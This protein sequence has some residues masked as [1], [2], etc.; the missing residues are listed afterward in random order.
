[1]KTIWKEVKDLMTKG[2]LGLAIIGM[3]SLYACQQ[4]GGEG[5]QSDAE[6]ADSTQMGGNPNGGSATDAYNMDTLK[7]TENTR[8]MDEVGTTAG[9]G[10]AGTTSEGNTDTT[11]ET[12]GTSSQSGL[13]KQDQ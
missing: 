11:S 2:T 10:A 6:T 7:G 13:K 12:G 1:M 3:T 9:T 8:G 4:S 5:G